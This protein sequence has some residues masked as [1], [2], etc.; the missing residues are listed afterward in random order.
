MYLLAV[1]ESD[2]TTVASWTT[3]RRIHITGYASAVITILILAISL[4]VG[5]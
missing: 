5:Q 1:I 2:L 4:S 3:N